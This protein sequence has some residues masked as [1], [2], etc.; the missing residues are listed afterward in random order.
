[1]YT[2]IWDFGELK[3]EDEAKILDKMVSIF[4]SNF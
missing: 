2:F 1:M 4:E 3:S